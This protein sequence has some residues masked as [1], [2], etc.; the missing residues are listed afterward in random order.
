MVTSIIWTISVFPNMDLE[1]LTHIREPYLSRLFLSNVEFIYKTFFKMNPIINAWSSFSTHL[2]V[3][4]KAG[5]HPSDLFQRFWG[6]RCYKY[7]NK[8]GQHPCAQKW[9]GTAMHQVSY[10]QQSL[11]KKCTT[12]STLQWC[13]QKTMPC[14]SLH[15]CSG[16]PE[17]CKLSW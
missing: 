15:T 9:R 8:I 14:G 7:S 12:L 2:Q 13:I 3:T 1:N 5:S 17:D 4:H 10:P 6:R 16:S 11:D